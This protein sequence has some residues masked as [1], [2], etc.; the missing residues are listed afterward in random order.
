MNTGLTDTGFRAT[1]PSDFPQALGM[2]KRILLVEDDPFVREIASEIL[3]S[4]G[5][6]VLK[7]RDAASAKA[8]SEYR[9]IHLL[10]TDVV[11]PGQNGC[12]LA[13]DLRKNN[14]ALKVILMSGYPRNGIL[15]KIAADDGAV[16]LPKPFTAEA[17]LKNVWQLLG[18]AG[19]VVI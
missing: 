18:N 15:E 6:Y 13:D 9:Q 10:I 11:L 1:T 17:L 16:Y 3:E 12:R 4:A 14:P 2:G 8:A 19:A 5:C 7:A